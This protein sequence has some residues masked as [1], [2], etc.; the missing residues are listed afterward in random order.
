MTWC[1]MKQESV[2]L[3]VYTILWKV[4][5]NVSGPQPLDCMPTVRIKYVGAFIQ[6]NLESWLMRWTATTMATTQTKKSDSH[7]SGSLF[8]LAI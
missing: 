1:I 2:P 5:V 4:C 8:T 3:Q 7:D 6:H